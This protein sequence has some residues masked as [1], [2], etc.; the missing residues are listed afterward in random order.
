M[1]VELSALLH[2]RLSKNTSLKKSCIGSNI[3]L[4]RLNTNW[5]DELKTQ[6]STVAA[7]EQI[8]PTHQ[9]THRLFYE[10]VFPETGVIDLGY[11]TKEIHKNYELIRRAI[12]L[13]RIIKP[14]S[15]G[16]SPVFVESTYNNLEEVKHQS[17]PI[18]NNLNVGFV[19]PDAEIWNTITDKDVE[20][21]IE[22]WNEF[23]VFFE[24]EFLPKPIY[25]RILR[26]IRFS[27]SAYA[28]PFAEIS[29]SVFHT[30]L[31]TLI[32]SSSNHNKRQIVKRLPQIMP[33]I[34]EQQAEEIYLLCCE[35][36]HTAAKW[37]Q[38]SQHPYQILSPKDQSRKDT[39][40]LLRKTIREIL[41]KAIR[42]NKFAKTLADP[43]L[44]KQTYK[45]YDSRKNLI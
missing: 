6:C 7:M 42:N 10:F 44:L 16:Y 9:F 34:S 20:T 4:E 3:F 40:S 32:C 22:L 2:I 17:N 24:D 18:L 26:A 11:M 13:S 5:L 36:K 28:I 33:S 38:N 23:Q 41:I 37:L 21:I 35:F 14:T 30:A 45:V 25:S 19:D 31:E 15:L 27:E 12:V 8:I 39:V 43:K 1:R 29:H